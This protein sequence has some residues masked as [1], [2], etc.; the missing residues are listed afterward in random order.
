MS[1]PNLEGKIPLETVLAKFKENNKE[2]KRNLENEESME[3]IETVDSIANEIKAAK[4]NTA[5]KTNKFIN[6][7]KSGLGEEVKKNPNGIKIIEKP[8]IPWY[9]KL[10]NI[11]K[12]IFTKF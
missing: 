9:T 10:G 3:K 6:E 7:I 4:M 11:I 12:G 5:M 1:K 2:F 8:K